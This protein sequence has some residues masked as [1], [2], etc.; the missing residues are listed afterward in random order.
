[1]QNLIITILFVNFYLIFF[2][3]EG[4][5]LSSIEYNV[6]ATVMFWAL[7]TKPLTLLDLQHT[8]SIVSLYSDALYVFM[9]CVHFPLPFSL[10]VLSL[11][12]ICYFVI[13]G[14][15]SWFMGW[16]YLFS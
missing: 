7:A 3:G 15:R 12:W 9:F 10:G 5:F 8:K 4:P 1:M 13:C 6:K 16:F 2:S 14:M 11:S